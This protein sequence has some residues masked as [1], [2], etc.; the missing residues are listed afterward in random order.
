MKTVKICQTETVSVMK[1]ANAKKRKEK[2]LR[3]TL[4]APELLSRNL[5]PSS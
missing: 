5:Q 1:S 2:E 4:T 3:A